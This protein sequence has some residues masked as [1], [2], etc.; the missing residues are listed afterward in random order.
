[1][2]DKE[3]DIRNK[4]MNIELLKIYY[5][6]W[7][8]RQENLWKRMILFFVIIFFVSTLPTTAYMFDGL[9]LPKVSAAIFPICGLLL[10]VF[11]IWY[12]FAESYRINAVNNLMK[13]IIEANF[14]VEYTKMGLTSFLEHKGGNKKLP[15]KIF[16]WRMAI[17]VPIFL[18]VVEVLVAVGMLVLIR[19][20]LIAN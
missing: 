14:S 11:Y 15:L 13:K 4:E 1:M 18:T 3:L 8:F 6:E 17:W 16:T 9:R 2:I 5:E 7:K 19:M 12:C 20:G 10:S